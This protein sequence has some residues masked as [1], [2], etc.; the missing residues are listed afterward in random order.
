[1]LSFADI[2]GPFGPAKGGLPKVRF[3]PEAVPRHRRHSSL[4]VPLVAAASRGSQRLWDVV[5]IS[6][7]LALLGTEVREYGRIGSAK[8]LRIPVGDG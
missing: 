7:L 1:M 4:F 8:S 2:N 6:H 3:A 5:S